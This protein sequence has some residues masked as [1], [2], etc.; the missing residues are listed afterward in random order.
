MN[1]P[2]QERIDAARAA[3]PNDGDG[4]WAYYLN[5]EEIARDIANGS[6]ARLSWATGAKA[7][8]WDVTRT[9]IV[10]STDGWTSSTFLP[11]AVTGRDLDP[12]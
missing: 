9:W 4:E 11:G 3:K 8:T 2:E 12:V 7:R 6:A 1:N 10:N 5:G